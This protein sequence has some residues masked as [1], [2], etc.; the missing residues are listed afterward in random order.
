MTMSKTVIDEAVAQIL[1]TRVMD[2]SY[3][4]PRLLVTQ[5]QRGHYIALSHC[6]GSGEKR[7][8]CTTTE[9][10]KEHISGI[11][12]TKVP[13]TFQDAIKICAEIGYQYLW[14]DSLCILQDSEEDWIRESQKMGS[15]YER[16]RLTIAASGAKDPS[17]G[18]FVFNRPKSPVVE[19]PYFP[20]SGVQT[21]SILVSLDVTDFWE[22]TPAVGPL[23]Q[24][25]WATQEWELSRRMVHYMPH[26]ISWKCKF[27]DAAIDDSDESY[28]MDKFPGWCALIDYYS[29]CKLTKESDKLIA[30][31]GIANEMQKAR[32][33]RYYLGLWSG[34]LPEQLLWLGRN[35]EK[36]EELLGIPSWTWASMKG[37]VWF[38]HR[39]LD[40]EFEDV[41][42]EIILGQSR[43]LRIRGRTKHG[44]CDEDLEGDS[45][46]SLGKNLDQAERFLLA[47][48]PNHLKPALYRIK[49]L[50]GQHK[51][52]VGLAVFDSIDHIPSKFCCL[53]LMKGRG[54]LGDYIDVDGYLVLLLESSSPDEE[55]YQRIGI[56]IITS[57]SWFDGAVSGYVSII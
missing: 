34:E 18:C 57:D 52:Y 6:W 24:R 49:D 9:N 56:G 3:G 19:V 33:D 29:E 39:D 40:G 28:N 16:A 35:L 23:R 46:Y 13:K 54:N 8:L 2:I 14:I 36:N 50:D 53:S 55:T 41:C 15:I 7:P 27:S 1:P 22:K 4:Q 25:A 20:D 10:L 31:Q 51:E 43:E 12:F 44:T 38:P 5:N 42:D 21:G 11:P 48:G 37:R 47:Y 30:L 45:D 32:Q 26:G 17:G